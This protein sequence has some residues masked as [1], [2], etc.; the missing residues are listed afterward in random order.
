MAS[1]NKVIILGRLG[2][3][4]EI[5]NIAST[6]QAVC[7]I[8]VATSRKYL[9][10]SE[11]VEETEWHSVTIFGRQAETVAQYM[12]KG[13]EIYLE[14]RLKTTK[15]TDNQG[16]ERWRTEI[17]C[18]SFQ[19]GARADN[20]SSQAPKPAPAVQKPANN[21]SSIDDDEIPF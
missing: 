1:V 5:R 17:I 12:K 3:D 14:G 6:G 8:A 18:E 15:Y 16:V 20:D 11:K 9:K 4:P 21:N 19:F 10:G 13:S 7:R 2:R